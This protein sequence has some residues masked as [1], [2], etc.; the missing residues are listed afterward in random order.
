MPSFWNVEWLN[1]NTQRAYPLAEHATKQDVSRTITLPDSFLVEL[2]WPVAHVL[3]L[4]PEKFYIKTIAI[5]GGGYTLAL[6]Y[7]DG[8]DDPPTVATTNISALT[9]AENQRYAL[10]GVNDYDDAVGKIVVGRVTDIGLLPAGVYQFDPADTPLDPDCVRPM[11]RGVS[12]ISIEQSGQRSAKLRDNIV[13][14]AGDNMRL[15]VVRL[16]DN[17]P[18]VR[19]D[20]V[21]DTTFTSQ[22]DCTETEPPC[23]R[24]INDIPGDSNQNFTLVG[25]QCIR[26]QPITHGLQVVDECCTPCCGDAELKEVLRALRGVRNS[27]A[28]INNFQQNLSAAM[29]QLQIN[30]AL[31]GLRGCDC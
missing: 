24:T 26:F 20:A 19:F 14:V 17:P 18:I 11:I 3:S 10:V 13:F 1:A 5:L 15:T 30:L 16:D 22:C 2:S 9:D 6:G 29:A 7:D 23:I 8:T 28:T 31:S 12:S 4:Q 25:D 21:A 27:A